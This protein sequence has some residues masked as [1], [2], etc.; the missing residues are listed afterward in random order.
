MESL[1]RG[2]KIYS[3]VNLFELGIKEGQDFSVL[4]RKTIR[5]AEMKK[6]GTQAEK[7]GAFAPLKT[8][9]VVN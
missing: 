7:S 5:E 9:H 2:I 4:I 1:R 8:Q 6:H 3:Q